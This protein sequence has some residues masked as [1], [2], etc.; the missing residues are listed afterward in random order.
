MRKISRMP[1]RQIYSAKV[2]SPEQRIIYLGSQI[3]NWS[4]RPA[5]PVGNTAVSMEWRCDLLVTLKVRRMTLSKQREPL[6]NQKGPEKER[7]S[8]FCISVLCTKENLHFAFCNY[9]LTSISVSSTAS[10]GSAFLQILS[11]LH[12]HSCL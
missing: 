11:Y 3:L 7:E 10:S 4:L 6:M 9:S 2:S 1:A 5:L 12:L 8:V